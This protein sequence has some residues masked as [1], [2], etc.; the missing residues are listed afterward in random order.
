LITNET[1]RDQKDRQSLAFPRSC[2]LTKTDEFSSVF[3]FKRALRGSLFL[4]HYLPRNDASTEARL[5]VVV[6]K[7][8]VKRAVGRNLIK[9]I[10]RE[11]FR[12]KRGQLPACDLILRLASKPARL[13]RQQFAAEIVGLLEKLQQR[14]RMGRL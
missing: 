2:R 4:L 13:D 14:G 1:E 10:A 8:L 6:A 9:R 7:K 11:Q 12:Q 5:G 3:G